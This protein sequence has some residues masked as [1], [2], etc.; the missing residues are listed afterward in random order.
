[1]PKPRATTELCRRVRAIP[2]LSLMN[3][4]EK[5]RPKR[6]PRVSAIGGEN[7][8]VKE[9]TRPR[10]KKIFARVGIDW[11]KNIR[12]GA[13]RASVLFDRARPTPLAMLPPENVEMLQRTSSVRLRWRELAAVGVRKNRSGCL[14]KRLLRSGRGCRKGRLWRRRARRGLDGRGMREGGDDFLGGGSADLAVPV[15]DAAL[16]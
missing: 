10:A 1:M 4:C 12:P 15:V 11:E 7:H 9:R 3:G 8:P 6:I 14:F 13:E 16:G 5:L 2:R